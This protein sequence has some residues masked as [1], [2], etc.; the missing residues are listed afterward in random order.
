VAPPAGAAR[1]SLSLA[2]QVKAAAST[3]ECAVLIA[4]SNDARAGF[5]E[6]VDGM[7]RALAGAGFT[8]T[9]IKPPAQNGKAQFEGAVDAAIKDGCKN[10]LLYIAS[11]GGNGSM[12][13]GS[14]TYTAADMKALIEKNPTVT[15]K[16]VLQGCKTGSW[17]APLAGKSEIMITSTDATKPSYSADPDGANDPNP[18]D[19]GSEFTSGLV[20]DIEL[21]KTTPG[22]QQRMQNCIQ[23][24]PFSTTPIPG[25]PALVCLLEIAYESALAKDEDAKAG[26]SVPGIKLK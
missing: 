9:K 11:H 5:L 18:D 7:E 23:G 10:I 24:N 14:G 16:V 1:A 3:A 17:V 8:T 15:F 12:N 2:P 21:I 22:L 13:M 4:G 25:K 26:R 6:D 20:E 19:K